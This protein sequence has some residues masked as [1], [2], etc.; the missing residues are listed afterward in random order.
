MSELSTIGVYRLGERLGGGMSVVYRAH[1]LVTGQAVALKL[2]LLGPRLL[3]S[4][5]REIDALTRIKHPGIVQ[6]LE[7]G[8]VRGRPWFSMELLEG[9]SLRQRIRLAWREQGHRNSSQITAAG[10]TESHIAG[11][12]AAAAGAGVRTRV[13][14][15]DAAKPLPLAGGG[16]LMSMLRTARRLCAALSYLHGENLINGDI[17]PE[18]ILFRNGLP[19]LIDFG[20]ALTHPGTAGRE[21]LEAARRGAGT[22]GYMAPEQLQ[23]EFLD[24]RTDLYAFGCVLYEMVTGLPPHAA[25]LGT[26]IHVP[27][28]VAPSALVRELP[29]A[30]E[31]LIMK[32]LS[33]ER[34][35]RIG[36]ADEV[37]ARLAE[38]TGDLYRLA[39]LPPARPY[40]Y[41]PRLRDRDESLHWLEEQRARL[42]QGYGSFLLLAG[43]SGSGKTRLA[44]ELTRL[45]PGARLRIVTSENSTLGTAGGSA[46]FTPVPL[47][48]FRPFLRALA[49][50]C[51]EHGASA[52]AHL[53][54]ERLPVLAKYEPLLLQLEGATTSVPPLP[55]DAA[56]QRLFR[57]IAETLRDF[58]DE[59]PILFAIDDLS[60]ADDLS[61]AALQFLDA[62]FFG[63]TALMIVAT[64]R[65]EETTA[66]IAAL[67]A[68]PDVQ[69]LRLQRLSEA[70]LSAMIG[71]MLAIANPDAAFV[72]K[73]SAQAEGNPFFAAEYLR[74]AVADRLIYRGESTW[75]FPR[76]S[77]HPGKEAEPLSVPNS[78]RALVSRRLQS[79]SP[80]AQGLLQLAAVFGRESELDMLLSCSQLSEQAGR[81]A[82][83]ELQERYILEPHGP[84]ALRFVH[85]K[86]REVAYD[87]I[88]LDQLRALHRLAAHSLETRWQRVGEPPSWLSV[89]GHHYG[90]GAE[91]RRAAHF[92]ARAADY[93]SSSSA[94]DEAVLLYREAL[95][96][97]RNLL[98]SVSADVEEWREFTARR[99]EE[100]ADLLLL[101]GQRREARELLA[102]ALSLCGSASHVASARLLRKQGKSWEFDHDHQRALAAYAEAG[103][104]LTL[105]TEREAAWQREWVQVRLDELWI[106][107]WRG[108]VERMTLLIGEL[109]PVLA[110]FASSSQQSKYFISIFHM[111]MRRERYL[112]SAQTLGFAS[113]SVECCQGEEAE[114]ELPGALFHHGMALMLYGELELAEAQLRRALSLF[115]RAGNLAEQAR[116]STYL[117]C[118]L[119]RRGDVQG[120]REAVGGS[121]SLSMRAQMRDYVGAA[122][123]NLAW[124]SLRD[125]D[126]ARARA[127][128]LDAM[129]VWAEL[130]SVYPY[131]FQWMGLLPLLQLAAEDRDAERCRD[132][133]RALCADTQ[134][135]L[136][137]PV[138]KVLERALQGADPVEGVDSL[139]SLLQT[140]NYS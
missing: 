8:V 109:R 30:V 19:V 127:S 103:A 101:S 117:T 83:D 88:S 70:G 23:G 124:L 99:S 9:D 43:E 34:D 78:I 71:D 66:G 131:P 46:P 2:G 15:R 75:I 47:N 62:H 61:L 120:V 107:Y 89:L 82:V 112:L 92:L 38:I 5:R 10:H 118:T 32:L 27:R 68:R 137:E 108:D 139:L 106:Q 79:L 123:A 95:G 28:P 53:L 130:A 81:I 51:Q 104:R 39:A 16:E 56:R 20:L 29:E 50:Y 87:E 116:T 77:V 86:I 100:L 45:P 12:V 122:H 136:S 63:N 102:E 76:P 97:A 129:Q 60:W 126:R 73:V 17:K 22:R 18:N 135:R 111:N 37:E 52:T 94:L 80:N 98:L 105:T 31:S 24:A 11:T 69:T 7:H 84:Q 67:A 33:F 55:P 113:S 119:R 114:L 93:A 90:S 6:I 65:S 125:G 44:M 54:G 41:R 25:P 14:P 140:E 59:R 13:N 133:L 115:E 4:V 49:D 42:T 36:Y 57:Y 74:N 1:N 72:R 21:L 3:E 40:L 48:V 138:G 96:H 132:L 85:D 134:Q 128:A 58:T 121:L 35:E 26:W 91:P 64:Y 110:T